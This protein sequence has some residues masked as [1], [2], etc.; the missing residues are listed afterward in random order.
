M[1][2]TPWATPQLIPL[3]LAS[4]PK[5]SRGTTVTSSL[6]PADAMAHDSSASAWALWVLE[7]S[8]ASPSPTFTCMLDIEAFRA[9]ATTTNS[10]RVTSTPPSVAWI[11]S[12]DA[13]DTLSIPR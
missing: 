9:A 12:V 8:L 4:L 7:Q 2:S 10:N 13:V 11:S 3:T 6:S 5:L 1:Y